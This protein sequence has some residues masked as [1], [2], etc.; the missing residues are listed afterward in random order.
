MT[1]H[2]LGTSVQPAAAPQLGMQHPQLAW[3]SQEQPERQQFA[4]ALQ[5]ATGLEATSMGSDWTCCLTLVL[6]VPD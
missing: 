2:A 4:L 3:P 1:F 6:R 5:V